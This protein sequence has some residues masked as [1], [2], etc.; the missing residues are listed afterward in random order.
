MQSNSQKGFLLLSAFC[1][2]ENLK[3]KFGIY[4]KIS[5]LTYCAAHALPYQYTLT[6]ASCGRPRRNFKSWGREILFQMK[7]GGPQE[8]S[9]SFKVRQ[10]H[11]WGKRSGPGRRD[12]AGASPVSGAFLTSGSVSKNLFFDT[13]RPGCCTPG[14]LLYKIGIKSIAP[15]GA[16]SAARSFA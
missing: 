6:G 4:R 14:P 13:L 9:M 3:K 2:V 16:E 12:F 5:I 8:Y 11:S 7:I 15:D 1:I 10:A